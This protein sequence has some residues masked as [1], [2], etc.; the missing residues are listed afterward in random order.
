MCISKFIANLRKLIS[1]PNS[2]F[3]TVQQIIC[4]KMLWRTGQY[5]EIEAMCLFNMKSLFHDNVRSNWVP[6]C[7]LSE[8]TIKQKN[9]D[10]I[11]LLQ[12]KIFHMNDFCYKCAVH[13]F[14]TFGYSVQNYK[15]LLT[16]LCNTLTGQVFVQYQTRATFQCHESGT[17]KQYLQQKVWL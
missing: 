10:R 16:S 15:T 12:K 4:Q 9:S 7:F 6:K 13:L 1:H 17:I 3:L 11:R 8:C 5:S 2:L 14:K